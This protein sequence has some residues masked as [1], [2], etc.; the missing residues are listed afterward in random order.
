MDHR[1][2]FYLLSL[3]LLL[4]ICTEV[5]AGPLEDI[6]DT[7]IRS[8]SYDK[9][10]EGAPNLS[11]PSII[12][13]QEALELIERGNW[14]EAKSRLLLAANLSGDYPDPLFTLAKNELLRFDPDFLP[15]LIEGF[16]R[17]AANFYVQSF[18]I[19]NIALLATVAAIGTLL[20]V[21]LQLLAKY[22]PLIE[23]SIRERYSAKFSFPPANWIGLMLLI[24]FISMRAGIAL[25]IS[26]LMLF[27]WTSLRLKEKTVVLGLVLFVSAL[28]FFSYYSNALVPPLDAGSTTRRLSLINERGA[29]EELFRLIS[30]I[31]DPAYS[32]ERDYALGTL[33]YRLE[34]LPEAK[35]YLLSSISKNNG[36][37]PAYLNL[38]NVYFKQGDY[39]KAL[40][41]YQNAISVDAENAIAHYN[42]AQAYIKMMLFAQ[43]STALKRASELDIEKYQMSHPSTRFRNLTIYEEGF[44]TRTLW[45]LAYREGRERER[46]LF[47]EILRPLL[48]FP[49]N[50]L[51]IL[52]LSSAFVS[53]VIGLR[54]PRSKRAFRCDNCE[55]PACHACADDELGIRLCRDCA[56]VV[57]G[58]SSVKVMEALLRHRRQK[59]LKN[60]SKRIKRRMF[61]VPGVAHMHYGKTFAGAFFIFLSI[62]AVTFLVWRGFYFKEPSVSNDAAPLWKTVAPVVCLL[63]CLVASLTKKE[64]QESRPYWIL[65]PELRE[66]EKKQTQRK[67]SLKT[68]EYPWETVDVT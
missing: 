33:L 40:A 5:S 20:F 61:I 24:A 65:P 22:W 39:D 56:G 43:S 47:G 68:E 62:T 52:L 32:A 9:V 8:Y 48:L 53:I 12:I 23:H 11:I 3:G 55:R 18:V 26:I 10:M 2:N 64:T 59:I 60:I 44:A 17:L 46:I 4:A 63:Y 54:V 51:W 19:A 13:Y 66:V 28:S 6:Q 57:E 21:L 38:G 29:D 25:Y 15:H 27:V 1:V 45:R 67:A 16:T 50:R 41:G 34:I 42:L 7:R 37:A 35:S 58:L 14:Q 31:E 30:G 49:F 36:F